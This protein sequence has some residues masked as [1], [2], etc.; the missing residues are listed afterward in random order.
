[1]KLIT[2]SVPDD[3]AYLIP[4]GDI[5]IGDK[6]FSKVGRG[7][8][9]GYLDWVLEHPESKIFLMGDVYN[10][11]SRSSKTS[12]FESSSAEYQEAIDLFMPVKDQIIGAITGNHERRME[13]AFGFNPLVPFCAALGTP[14]LGY[15]AIIRFKVGLRNGEAYERYRQT[16]HIYAHHT[17]GGGGTLGASVNRKVKLQE[18]VQGCDIY[19]GGHSHQLVTG[20]RSVFEPGQNDIVE[21]KVAYVD[22]GSFLDWNGSYAEAGQYT[23]GKLGAPRIRLSGSAD[24]HDVHVSL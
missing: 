4:I 15:S 20:F 17:T 3:K 5:H 10:T 23:P 1:M 12:P 21:R 24:K 13:D 22:T 18:L 14:Y 19:M 16:Y 11:A 7:K 2:T 9:K 6:A 8:L